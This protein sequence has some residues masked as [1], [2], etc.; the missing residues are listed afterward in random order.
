MLGYATPPLSQLSTRFFV[1]VAAVPVSEYEP[2]PQA[3]VKFCFPVVV[4]VTLVPVNEYE[5][6]AQVRVRFWDDEAAVTVGT[7]REPEAL[8][9]VVQRSGVATLSRLKY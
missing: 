7:G 6:A 5:P 9:H 8:L 4:S 2:A 3:S 1:S